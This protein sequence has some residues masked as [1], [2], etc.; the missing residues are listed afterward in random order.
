ME[1]DV[2]NR[3]NKPGRS[4]GLPAVIHLLANEGKLLKCS[5]LHFAD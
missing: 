4:M 2:Y 5:R 3:G 1:Q